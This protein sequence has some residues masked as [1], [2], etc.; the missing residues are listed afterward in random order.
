MAGRSPGPARSSTMASV[1]DH[2]GSAVRIASSGTITLSGSRPSRSLSTAC[3]TAAIVLPPIATETWLPGARP[4]VVALAA[5]TSSGRTKRDAPVAGCAASA[6]MR[7]AAS[8]P[9]AA[10]PLTTRA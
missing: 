1:P 8:R 3:T 9:S 4:S 6:A 5:G 2:W 7:S 10:V